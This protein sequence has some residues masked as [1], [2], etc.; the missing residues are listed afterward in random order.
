M[1][2]DTQPAADAVW[3]NLAAVRGPEY[4]LVPMWTDYQLQAFTP[5]MSVRDVMKQVAAT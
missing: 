3:L 1:Q 2:S 5:R 4:H